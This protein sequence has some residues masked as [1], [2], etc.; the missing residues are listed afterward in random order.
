M[1]D[2]SPI[3]DNQSLSLPETPSSFEDPPTRV[4]NGEEANHKISQNHTDISEPVLNTNLNGIDLPLQNPEV[5][6]SSS[7]NVVTEEY[8]Q[9]SSTENFSNGPLNSNIVNQQPSHS[10]PSVYSTGNPSSNLGHQQQPPPYIPGGLPQTHTLYTPYNANSFQA[11]SFLSYHP[12]NL[13]SDTGNA[14]ADQRANPNQ[15][16]VVPSY[17]SEE[18]RRR[19]ID[20]SKLPE[21]TRLFVG[22]LSTDRTTA[23]ELFGIFKPYGNILEILMKKNFA[24][25]QFD[26][27]ASCTN[28]MH[29]E[30]KRMFFLLFNQ[31]HFLE[32][33]CYPGHIAII[34]FS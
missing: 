25:V 33:G 12:S 11:P 27:E 32:K 13:T 34:A 20:F 19:G 31:T 18:S 9:N 26:N 7:E 6:V 5:A 29:S 28:A 14:T 3:E 30:N 4:D 21:K 17:S 22:H 8:V 2:T 10:Y 23:E 16:E 24:F 1:S 15:G